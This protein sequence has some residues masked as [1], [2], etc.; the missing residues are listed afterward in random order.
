MLCRAHSG[1]RYQVGKGQNPKPAMKEQTQPKIFNRKAAV[2]ALAASALLILYQASALA[3]SWTE[4]SAPQ[5]FW[6]SVAASAGG[7][8]LVAVNNVGPVYTSKDSGITWT[9]SNAG[10][11]HVYGQAVASS[12]DGRVLV[13]GESLVPWG[14]GYIYISTNSGA[15]WTVKTQPA[16]DWKSM[17]SSADGSKLVAV[18]RGGPIYTSMDSGATWSVRASALQWT[19]VAS[20]ADGSKMVATVGDYAVGPI[21]TS[22]NSGASWTPVSST[23]G[24]WRAVASSADGTKLVAAERNNRL[25]YTSTNSGV[26]WTPTSAPNSNWWSVASSA[27]GS[28]L[29]AAVWQGPIYTSTDS[30]ATWINS[31]AP[32]AMWSSV[33]SSAD[34]NRL[35]AVVDGWSI[36][37]RQS[38]SQLIPVLNLSLSG[39]NVVLTWP[40]YAADYTLQQNTNLRT[41]N[42]TPVPIIPTITSE[43]CRVELSR[44]N[45]SGFYRLTVP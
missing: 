41:T 21:Y 40:F 2:V 36:F 3:Q 15:N 38:A 37:T 44:T 6:F 14:T 7:N 24:N 32:S 33:A 5:A 27:D 23:T 28:K 9:A 8:K 13:V 25:I 12:S 43:Q 34:G 19:G 22:G 20:S 26:T 31:G 45:L 39:N 10:Y 17:A 42:W 35:V 1:T 4:A 11:G 29:V 30:G 18:A 16:Q